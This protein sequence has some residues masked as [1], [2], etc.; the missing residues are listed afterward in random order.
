MV[1]L[2]RFEIEFIRVNEQVI[3]LMTLG[4]SHLSRSDWSLDDEWA[5]AVT[6]AQLAR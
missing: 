1:G 4:A 2:V 5:V 6:D 3:G